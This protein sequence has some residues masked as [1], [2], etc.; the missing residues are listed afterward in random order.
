[1][2]EIGY[3]GGLKTRRTN[4]AEIPSPIGTQLKYDID[5]K[6]DVTIE[7][8]N[9]GDMVVTFAPYHAI[10]VADYTIS[11]TA[12]EDPTDAN[13]PEEGGGTKTA[14]IDWQNITIEA[15]QT[16]AVADYPWVPE[17]G[18]SYEATFTSTRSASTPQ[19]DVV[20]VAVVTDP[21]YPDFIDLKADG[22]DWRVEFAVHGT[23]SDINFYG[24]KST[25]E[26]FSLTIYESEG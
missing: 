11:V 15:R 22:G 16:Y 4:R 2:Y 1:M 5:R 9:D 21:E 23:T 20:L 3:S 19:G 18:K 8:E 12:G 24:A 26:T 10:E 17:V 7:A 6:Q 25:G 14:V 13:C